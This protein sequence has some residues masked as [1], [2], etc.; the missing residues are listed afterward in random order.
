MLCSN[1]AAIILLYDVVHLVLSAFFIDGNFCI[2]QDAAKAE[3]QKLK[4]LEKAKE[5]KATGG[6]AKDKKDKKKDK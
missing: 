3:K 6:E 1:D 5:S 2:A 4:E